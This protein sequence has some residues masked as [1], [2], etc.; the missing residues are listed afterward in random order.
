LEY[1]TNTMK[2][3][4]NTPKCIENTFNYFGVFKIHLSIIKSTF[5]C[6]N[7]HTHTFQ[8]HNNTFQKPY[9]LLTYIQYHYYTPISFYIHPYTLKLSWDLSIP[10]LF[11]LSLTQFFK[12]VMAPHY[13]TKMSCTCHDIIV[14][15]QKNQAYSMNSIHLIG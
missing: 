8:I 4:I 12:I 13:S 10:H 6:F 5:L 14:G 15:I 9:I 1:T 2:Y 11:V 3:T 7:I